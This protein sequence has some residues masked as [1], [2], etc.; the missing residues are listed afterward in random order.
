M[1]LS[2]KTFYIFSSLTLASVLLAAGLF[3]YFHA[4]DQILD[5][6]KTLFHLSQ[7]LHELERSRFDLTEGHHGPDDLAF[8]K[9]V[10]KTRHFIEHFLQNEYVAG[11]DIAAQLHTILFQLKNYEQAALE[12]KDKYIENKQLRTLLRQSFFKI[13]E[14]LSNKASPETIMKLMKHIANYRKILETML[15]TA[16]FGRFPDASQ[17]A[18]QILSSTQFPELKPIL[19]DI[20]HIVQELY[21][22]SL[23]I[24]DRKAFLDASSEHFHK[25]VHE[26][27]KTIGS[28]TWESRNRFIRATSAISVLTVLL[29]IFFWICVQ[30]YF[31]N[32]LESQKQ[33]M[34]AIHAGTSDVDPGFTSRDEL[35]EL[36]RTLKKLAMKKEAMEQSLR[37][38]RSV[39]ESA[40][41]AKN[42]FLANM[43]HEI[44]TPLNGIQGMIQL[45][46]MTDLDSEQTEYAQTAMNST[47]RLTRLLADILDLSRVEAGK[48]D[49]RS[50]PFDLAE[51]LSSLE[52]LFS[53][54]ARQKNLSFQVQAD[55]LLPHTLVGDA[56]RLQQ[57]LSN[58]VGNAIK[59][60]DNGSITLQAFALP[61]STPEFARVLFCVSDTGIGIAETMLEQL[62]EPFEQGETRYRRRYQGAGLGLSIARQ[63]T[64]LMG[65]TLT[66]TSELNQ[67]TS[68]HLS[69]P[70]RIAGQRMENTGT[71]GM[72]QGREPLPGALNILLAED[73]AISQFATAKLLDRLGHRIT[74]AENGRR[75][76]DVLR[77]ERFDLVLMD[78]QMPV[79]DGLQ[80]TKTIRAGEAGRNNASIPIV[81]LTAYAMSGDREKFLEAG[82]NDYL[83]KPLEMDILRS[84][85]KKFRQRNTAAS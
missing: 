81:A 45:L 49:I 58:L 1:T 32:F 52:L 63:L 2:R 47:H 34:D 22:I 38:A 18:R 11:T 13:P 84:V 64:S 83:A 21:V 24:Q 74:T 67:G 59:F 50:V 66:V 54:A 36:T 23:A 39:A 26:A 80:A 6:T 72:G 30:R 76:L 85:L 57:I 14:L 3:Y 62:F 82:I 78:I 40:N 75:A 28:I 35:G 79:M 65:G 12:L 41:A 20:G 5:V 60:T 25:S 51:S 42:E 68:F 71:T 61:A 27:L 70:F 55:P 19:I 15:S 77:E 37:Q 8:R 4:E 56:A 9:Q 7:D 10:A 48:L 69:L 29:A 31:K 44:R 73:D 46:H 53:S 33:L 43:S 16:D 17:Q